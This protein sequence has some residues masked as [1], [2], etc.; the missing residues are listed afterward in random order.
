MFDYVV[1]WIG[2]IGVDVGCFE[3]FCVEVVVVYVEVDYE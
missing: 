1:G 3:F 2:C